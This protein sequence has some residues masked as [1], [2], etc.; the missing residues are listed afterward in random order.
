MNIERS[1]IVKILQTLLLLV[2]VTVS[3]SR[4]L[5][6][7]AAQPLDDA[8]RNALITFALVRSIN[9]VISV[10]QGTELAIEPAGIG[11]TLAPGEAFDPINDLVERFSW[12]VLAANTSLGV[13]QVLIEL[14]IT[15]LLQGLVLLSALIMLLN[16]WLPEAMSEKWRFILMRLALLLIT[17][18]FIVPMTVIMNELAY[19][20]F[21]AEKYESSFTELESAQQ[22][23]QE[24][25]DAEL[26]SVDAESDEGLLATIS[27]WY[28]STSQTINFSARFEEYERRLGNSAENIINLIVVFVLQTIIFPLA[29]FWL[30]IKLIRAMISGIYWQSPTGR[31]P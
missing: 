30:S 9:A 10:A 12:I 1:K 4:T 17:L 26:G 31:K 14:G 23:V 13:Q 8:F 21:L 16:T 2:L 19:D 7:H 28:N 22:S 24:L 6:N 29:L 20:F 25:Q 27:R 11:V 15:P 5:E 18:R 3:F